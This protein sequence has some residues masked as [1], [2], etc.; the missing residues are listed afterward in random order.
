M[1]SPVGTSRHPTGLLH[2]RRQLHGSYIAVALLFLA[3]G[4]LRLVCA[5]AASGA[6]HVADARGL[7]ATVSGAAA[8]AQSGAASTATAEYSTLG[9]KEVLATGTPLAPGS[10]GT[11][12]GT[13]KAVLK[14]S[15]A[16]GN[17]AAKATA[18]TDTPYSTSYTAPGDLQRLVRCLNDHQRTHTNGTRWS[19]ALGDAPPR[20]WMVGVWSPP[21]SLRPSRSNS[22][23]NS[24]SSNCTTAETLAAGA[25]AAAMEAAQT[26]SST[27]AAAA[28]AAAAASG[29]VPLTL[30]T[31][32]TWD[33]RWHLKTMC[34]SWPGPITAVLHVAALPHRAAGR[35]TATQR[36]AGALPDASEG[37]QQRAS[38]GS[39]RCA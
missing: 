32:L 22:S 29:G 14:G 18:D 9:M 7:Q 3:H 19:E 33:R 20:L 28:A 8:A 35:L 30:T 17:S 4:H 15:A 13:D 34:R 36:A 1:P 31:H 23:S 24:S 2:G 26:G 10:T 39:R 37:G 21:T 27:G 6:W 16:P 11:A 12:A 25:A 38:L 5:A